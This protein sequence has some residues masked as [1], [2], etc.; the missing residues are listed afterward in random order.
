MTPETLADLT[1]MQDDA[2]DTALRFL[3]PGGTLVYATCSVLRIENEARIT[4]L[5]A[6]HP[7]LEI[8]QTL[9]LH[10]ARDGCDG[11]FAAR[12]TLTGC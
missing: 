12:L 2:L 4:A 3:R 7:R 1:R 8:A 11:F 6:R 10:P 5:L 9:R